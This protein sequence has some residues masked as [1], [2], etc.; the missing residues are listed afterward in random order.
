M[1]KFFLKNS[2]IT[3]NVSASNNYK[4]IV[5]CMSLSGKDK[6]DNNM[7]MTNNDVKNNNNVS[8]D[9]DYNNMYVEL[10][11]KDSLRMIENIDCSLRYMFEV[12]IMCDNIVRI[13]KIEVDDLEDTMKIED[14]N[15]ID[16]AYPC[17]EE[18]IDIKNNLTH[19]IDKHL[20]RLVNRTA[21]LQEYKKR[22]NIQQKMSFLDFDLID[23]ELELYS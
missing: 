12:F 7:F 15:D 8:I 21:L 2:L 16:L 3:Q 14:N 18:I 9:I 20:Q 22:L 4:R 10:N 5:L 13:K 17:L 11:L 6:D 19:R 1:M 23:S